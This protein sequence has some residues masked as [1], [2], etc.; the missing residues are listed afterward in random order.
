LRPIAAPRNQFDQSFNTAEEPNN[1]TDIP[2]DL[3]VGL[4]SSLDG[5]TTGPVDAMGDPLN[6]G[7]FDQSFL[8]IDQNKLPGCADRIVKPCQCNG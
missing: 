6:N 2:D 7:T 1:T 4:V 5:I 3:S 8:Y